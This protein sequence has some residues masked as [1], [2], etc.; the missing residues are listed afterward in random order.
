[1]KEEQDNQLPSANAA[2]FMYQSMTMVYKMCHLNSYGMM[3]AI[4]AA[5]I[6]F[7]RE[8]TLREYSL[9]E[10]AINNHQAEIND[11]ISVLKEF[12]GFAVE[13]KERWIELKERINK[14]SNG[15][16]NSDGGKDNGEADQEKE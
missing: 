12:E 11:L 16:K 5:I 14:E 8:K 9:V 1:M 2:N 10:T 4:A 6:F 15:K 7:F 13:D 3:D